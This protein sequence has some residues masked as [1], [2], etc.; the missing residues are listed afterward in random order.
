MRNIIN[1]NK[2]V[3]GNEKNKKLKVLSFSIC[4][5]TLMYAQRIVIPCVLRK[6][7]FERISFGSSEYIQNEI[8]NEK[9]HVLAKNG[10][11]H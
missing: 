10:P 8:I 6:K 1:M 5:E 9:L 7:V 2:Q 3:K 4:D 11:G